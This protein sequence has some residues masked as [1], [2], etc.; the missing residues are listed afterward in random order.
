[1]NTG[2]I[3]K[4]GSNVATCWKPTHQTEPSGSSLSRVLRV[5]GPVYCVQ[6]EVYNNKK[7]LFPV[8]VII[9]KDKSYTIQGFH[10]ARTVALSLQLQYYESN[11][12]VWNPPSERVITL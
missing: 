7:V 3:V 4:C 2:L 12:L 1:M 5:W 6:R 11:A 9:E 8:F 10:I